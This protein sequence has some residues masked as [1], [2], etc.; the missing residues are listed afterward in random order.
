MANIEK[1]DELIPHYGNAKASMDE[2]KKLCDADNKEIKNIMG[3]YALQHYESGGYKVTRSV[4]ERESLDEDILLDI[5]KDIPEI[6]QS[7]II[8]T[9][10]YIDMDALERAIYAGALSNDTLLKMDKAKD[11]KTVVTLRI[12]KVK[13]KR[14]EE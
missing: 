10:E 11:T 3:D 6:A 12:S 7:D 5:L 13:K 4:T 2:Y 14:G 1:L 8:K 9:K